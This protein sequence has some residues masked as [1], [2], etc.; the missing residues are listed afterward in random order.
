M[1]PLGFDREDGSCLA[2][3]DGHATMRRNK[4]ND[5]PFY[6]CSNYPDCRNIAA[7]QHRV[8]SF[9]VPDEALDLAFFEAFYDGDGR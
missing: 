7:V 6:G 4:M 3:E 2:C 1:S 8:G 9:L 5:R